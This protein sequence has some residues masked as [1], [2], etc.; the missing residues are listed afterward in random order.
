MTTTDS[1]TLER[2][3]EQDQ[4]AH[5]ENTLSMPNAIRDGKLTPVHWNELTD[6]EQ[7]AARARMFQLYV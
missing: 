4:E 6:E 7:R 3:I 1:T 5:I 2:Q